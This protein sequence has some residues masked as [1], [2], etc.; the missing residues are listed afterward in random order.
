MIGKA[1]RRVGGNGERRGADRDMRLRHA[2]E[3]DHQRHGKD[4][5]AAA[6]EPEREADEHPRQRAENH[7]G[8]IERGG[9]G[10]RVG[11]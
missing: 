8:K 6:D 7:L 2:D 5:P 10:H 9:I 1:D 4:R 3:I 11:P